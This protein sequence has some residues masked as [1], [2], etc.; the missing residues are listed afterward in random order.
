MAGAGRRRRG[1]ARRGGGGSVD[2]TCFL[3]TRACFSATTGVTRGFGLAV[4]RLFGTT[5]FFEAGLEAR[6][7][8]TGFFE[9]G[10]GDRFGATGFFE[11]G[12]EA[13][14]GTTGLFETGFEARFFPA[15]RFETGFFWL[16]AFLL[17]GRVLV[18]TE[19]VCVRGRG[20]CAA[21]LDALRTRFLSALLAW[22]DVLPT[23]ADFRVFLDRGWRPIA[24]RVFGT[25]ARFSRLGFFARATDL[26]VRE[27]FFDFAI[28]S[29]LGFDDR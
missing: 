2:P 12:L 19:A 27:P 21:F 15:G 8:A 24:I 29:P 11:A 4:G 18:P 5:G 22:E 16:R 9:A 23:A 10:L 26:A 20:L 17:T 28:P 7:G 3:T 13:R 6:F 14:F 1:L 25:T